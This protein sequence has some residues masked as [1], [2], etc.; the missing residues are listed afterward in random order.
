MRRL[1]QMIEEEISKIEE[2]GITSANLESLYKMV[3][4]YKDLKTVESMEDFDYSQ[5]YDDGGNSYARGQHYVRG[6]YSRANRIGDMDNNNSNGYS[7]SDGN[8]DLMSKLSD[9]MRNEGMSQSEIS[10]YIKKLEMV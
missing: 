5:T 4:I 8:R 3:D 2:R 10:R 1:T 9:I 6:H 7:M